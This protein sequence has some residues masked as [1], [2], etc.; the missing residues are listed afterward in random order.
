MYQKIQ[1]LV[2]KEARAQA[3]AVYN[4]LGT[5]YNVA[6]VPTHLH[7]GIDSVPI[8]A[9]SVLGFMNLPA[10]SGGVA[11]ATTLGN[12]VMTQ[13]DA[14]NGYGNKATPNQ[15]VFSVYS[16]PIIY[17]NG[18]GLDGAFNGGDAPDGTVIMFDNGLTFATLCV[19]TGNGWYLFSPSAVI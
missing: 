3:T 10:T 6:K 11:N 1:E 14:V 15:A 4:E 16:I 17:G 13:G 8:P 12:Q 19:K 18:V 2:K 7:N 9:T 5:R